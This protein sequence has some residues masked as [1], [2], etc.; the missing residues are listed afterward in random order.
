MKQQNDKLS[1]IREH[2]RSEFR[3]YSLHD[4]FYQN[5]QKF[6]LSRDGEE[7][8][9][10]I[11]RRFISDCSAPRVR[12]TLRKSRFLSYPGNAAIDKIIYN[13][14]N[15]NDGSVDIIQTEKAP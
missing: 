4:E 7:Y 15:Y 11:E 10:I 3:G 1:Q 5:G 2:L 9:I 12:D 14:V 6:T 8:L 13:V